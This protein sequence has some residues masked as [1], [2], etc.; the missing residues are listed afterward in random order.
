MVKG[1]LWGCV[2]GMAT[3]L[4]S[5]LLFQ[6]FFPPKRMVENKVLAI[7]VIVIYFILFWFYVIEINRFLDSNSKFGILLI[8]L[9]ICFS[10][11]QYLLMPLVAEQKRRGN[12]SK[13]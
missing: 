13:W 1:L 9:S 8:D 12:Y 11:Y 4:L 2:G 5:Y 3:V 10:L 7:I 6:K